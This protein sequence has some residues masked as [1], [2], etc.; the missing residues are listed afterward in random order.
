MS[1]ESGQLFKQ[2]TAR[3]DR[4][5]I[6]KNCARS[7]RQNGV[8]VPGISTQINSQGLLPHDVRVHRD[9]DNALTLEFSLRA[10]KSPMRGKIRERAAV[11]A[12]Y[13]LMA[14][15]DVRSVSGNVSDGES[16]SLAGCAPSSADPD[17]VLVPDFFF[18]RD[19]GYA[20][21]Q[22]WF[23]ANPVAWQDRSPDIVWRGYANGTGLIPANAAVCDKPGVRQRVRMAHKCK[24]LGVDFKFVPGG[25]QYADC[26]FRS[27]GLIGD[28]HHMHSWGSRKF[29]IDIDG[30]TNAWCNLLRRLHLGCCVLKV[31]SDFG[32]RQWYYDDL[33]PWVHFVPVKAD[34]SDL[35]TQIE[36]VRSHDA[37]AEGIAAA[38]QTLARS[39]TFES[40]LRRAGQ[41]ITSNKAAAA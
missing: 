27:A 40:E 20:D 17:V 23:Q 29:A 41:I 11:F 32:Y 4:A 19:H 21:T 37:E 22:A 12:H 8:T 24:A 28:R 2:L 18:Y 26:L 10:L 16:A 38:G 1:F 5:N 9:D 39:M 35:E 30:Y 33:V 36:W 14:D 6:E 15:P 7:L 3:V 31:A 13:L 25:D 34:L